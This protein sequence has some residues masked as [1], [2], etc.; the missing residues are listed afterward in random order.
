MSRKK[1]ITTR[2]K[3]SLFVMRAAAIVHRSRSIRP[4]HIVVTPDY[5]TLDIVVQEIFSFFE[6]ESLETAKITMEAL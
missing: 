1:S 3:S 2:T 6:L 4:L 5:I